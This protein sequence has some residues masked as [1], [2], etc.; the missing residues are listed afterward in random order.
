MVWVVIT[1]VLFLLTVVGNVAWSYFN[2]WVSK[3]AMLQAWDNV[4]RKQK[5]LEAA[6]APAPAAEPAPSPA[7]APAPTPAPASS[8]PKPLTP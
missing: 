2:S 5:A 8:G 7:P 1:Y 3:M 4:L 6:P